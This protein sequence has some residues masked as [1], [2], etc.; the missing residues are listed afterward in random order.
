VPDRRPSAADGARFQ[1][2]KVI[3]LLCALFVVA[4]L[5]VVGV[6]AA[7]PKFR[8][9]VLDAVDWPAGPGTPA[10]PRELPAPDRSPQTLEGVLT[11]QLVTGEIT[12][13]QYR[14]AMASIAVRDAERHPLEV[15][16]DVTPPEAA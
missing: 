5:A 10:V 14:H 9:A 12:G 11:R 7:R 3:F 1:E 4:C 16:P 8:R 2:W 13:S 15:P 6:V